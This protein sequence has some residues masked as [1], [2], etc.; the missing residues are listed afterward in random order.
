MLLAYPASLRT[1]TINELASSATEVT[2]SQNMLNGEIR[3]VKGLSKEINAIAEFIK[4]IAD[5][6][7]LLGINATIEAARIGQNGLGFDVI[8]ERIRK[9]SGESKI[10]MDKV[11]GFIRQIND[12]VAKTSELSKV[13]LLMTRQEENGVK[14]IA[15]S[16][17]EFM[18]M[19]EILN[20][21]SKE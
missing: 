20:C 14:E 17:E 15:Q 7:Q 10:T 5:E 18:K 4:D 21:L 13:T 2:N 11:K 1:E 9:L 16:I 6:I 3:N 19:S 8:A 12:S